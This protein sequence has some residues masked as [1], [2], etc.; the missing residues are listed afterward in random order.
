MPKIATSLGI[1][2]VA[3]I[4]TTTCFSYGFLKD[5]EYLAYLTSSLNTHG[6]DECDN[7]LNSKDR[8][9]FETLFWPMMSSFK[10]TNVSKAK[11]QKQ[12]AQIRPWLD[13]P[14][15]FEKDLYSKI[16]KGASKL[17]E[18]DSYQTLHKHLITAWDILNTKGVYPY[19]LKPM[20]N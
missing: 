13:K 1:K 6:N 20:I 16:D 14:L 5:R 2:D 7:L 3:Q 19:P 4:Y 17:E 12:L 8:K 10:Y 18:S 11:F 15:Q 9:I